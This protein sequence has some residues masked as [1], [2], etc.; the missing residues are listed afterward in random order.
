MPLFPHTPSGGRAPEIVAT[1]LPPASPP[2]PGLRAL[3]QVLAECGPDRLLASPRDGQVDRRLRDAA[4]L[5]C[6]EARARDPRAEQLLID[7]KQ[8]WVTLPTVRAL[9]A[10]EVRDAL[11]RRLVAVCV[12]EFYGVR[13]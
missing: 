8:F 5:L 12:E 9:P 6:D 7:L 11:W 2:G 4:R 1:I 3:T 10:N 13:R